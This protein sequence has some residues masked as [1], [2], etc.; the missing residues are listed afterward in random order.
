MCGEQLLKSVASI[1]VGVAAAVL[2]GKTGSALTL[3]QSRKRCSSC[4][5]H[6]RE[7]LI[8]GGGEARAPAAEVDWVKAACAPAALCILAG[9]QQKALLFSKTHARHLQMECN[10]M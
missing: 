8:T 1:S 10:E 7:A 9:L 4:G 2:A 6:E 5:E 3:R